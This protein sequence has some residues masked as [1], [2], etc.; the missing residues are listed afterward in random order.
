M[1]RVNG[2][3]SDGV[4]S[5]YVVVGRAPGLDLSLHQDDFSVLWQVMSHSCSVYVL[6][7][8]CVC[9]CV[10]L[11][12]LVFCQA[13]LLFLESVWLFFIT[14]EGAAHPVLSRRKGPAGLDEILPPTP[15][16]PCSARPTLISCRGEST[17]RRDFCPGWFRTV[18]SVEYGT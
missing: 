18:Y 14:K 15:R 8:L 3:E 4:V 17:E 7:V 6:C 1:A 16:T 10:P 9:L 5:N 2:E 12:V 11:C 13:L